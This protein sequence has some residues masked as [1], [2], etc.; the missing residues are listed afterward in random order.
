MKKMKIEGIAT[1]S[2]RGFHFDSGV[3][4]NEPVLDKAMTLRGTLKVSKNGSAT[5]EDISHR[6]YL[7]P[8]WHP[9]SEDINYRVKRTSRHYIIQV[10]L[11]IV[12]SRAASQ[13]T[14]DQIVPAIMGDI[15]LDRKELISPLSPAASVGL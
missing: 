4:S 5:L 8:Q 10:K 14:L 9:V 6:I 15:T 2:N 1:I 13:E 7:P 12:E 3:P 11:P